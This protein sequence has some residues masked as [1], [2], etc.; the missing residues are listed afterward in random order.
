MATGRH[1]SNSVAAVPSS[2]FPDRLTPARAGRLTRLVWTG[3]LLLCST[4][5]TSVVNRVAFLPDR[6]Y[7][8]SDDLLPPGVRRIF[9]STDDGER[10]EAF[11]VT[12]S[13]HATKLVLYFH[14]NAGN[15]AQCLPHL[16]SFAKL[17]GATVLGLGYRGY[18]A[19]TGQPS[20]R[21]IYRDGEAALRFAKDELGFAES[22]IVLCGVS[23]GSAVA[24][25][26]AV[27][28]EFAGVILITPM[29]SAREL[30]RD[31]AHGSVAWLAGGAFDSL[32]KVPRL[33]S[34]V[35]VIHGTLDEVIPY[36]M[37]QKLFAAIPTP[38]RFVTIPGA[39]H[40]NVVFVDERTF[41]TA[42]SDF[43]AAPPEP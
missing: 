35:L 15:I 10:L 21:G 20:E 43:V 17:T 2:V 6:T 39:R 30:A 9:V 41:W 12:P 25:N 42:I 3:T 34:P 37:G 27:D 26:T 28:R 19:S 4:G 32:A 29:T 24:V 33:R 1:D 40:N 22:Q 5:C 31:H 13:E 23:L 16:Q 18:G 36:R 7:T 14:G 38:K 11:V 8:V